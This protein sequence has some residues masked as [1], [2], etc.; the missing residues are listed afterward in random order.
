MAKAKKPTGGLRYIGNGAFLPQVPARDLTP[1]EV[2]KYA[3]LLAE[4][5]ASGTKALL[6][7]AADETPAQAEE[8]V[9][10]GNQDVVEVANG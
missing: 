1:A 5:E 3:G 8:V 10:E 6:Y 4:A 7:V 2:E 9:G